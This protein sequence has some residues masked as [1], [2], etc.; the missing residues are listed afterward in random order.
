M[1]FFDIPRIPDGYI[2]ICTGFHR[3]YLFCMSVYRYVTSQ[4]PLNEFL[5][6]LVSVVLLQLLDKVKIVGTIGAQKR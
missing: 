6:N 4:E 3:I 1:F 5:L 2:K